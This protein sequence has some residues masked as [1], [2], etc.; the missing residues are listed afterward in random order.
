MIIINS[1][2]ITETEILKDHAVVVEADIIKEIIPMTAADTE[3]ITE[4]SMQRRLRDCR[5]YRYTL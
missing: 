1:N 5:F 4:S 2:V 3:D